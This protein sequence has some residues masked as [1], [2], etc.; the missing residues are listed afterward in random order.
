MM[1]EVGTPPLTGEGAQSDFA[2]TPSRSFGHSRIKQR[3]FARHPV[4][5]RVCSLKDE[6]FLIFLQSLFNTYPLSYGEMEGMNKHKSDI[7]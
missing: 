1:K 2:R 5:G 4:Q 6:S 3:V 7:C